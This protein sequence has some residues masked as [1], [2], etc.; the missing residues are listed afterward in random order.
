MCARAHARAGEVGRGFVA[1]D[2]NAAFGFAAQ[3]VC[4]RSGLAQTRPGRGVGTGQESGGPSHMAT[5][6]RE[7]CAARLG[8]EQGPVDVYS[9]GL[10]LR[11]GLLLGGRA[12][13][14]VSGGQGRASMESAPRLGTPGSHGQAQGGERQVGRG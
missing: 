2:P 8:A 3:Q 10:S 12:C 14:S 13:E 11:A 4:V 7:D 6:S 5:L 1:K 9:S